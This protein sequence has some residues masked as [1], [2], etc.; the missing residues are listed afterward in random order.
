ML[1]DNFFRHSRALA[2]EALPPATFSN[3]FSTLAWY[4]LEIGDGWRGGGRSGNG[5][6]RYRVA[7]ENAGKGKPAN[8]IG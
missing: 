5:S 6:G 7:F 8:R 3:M 1:G 4:D 2:Y